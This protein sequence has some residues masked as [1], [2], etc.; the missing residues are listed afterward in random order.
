MIII[1]NPTRV[2]FCRSGL[3]SSCII[4]EFWV[5]LAESKINC[6]KQP[7]RGVLR[8]SCSENMQHIYKRTPMPKSDFNKVAVHFNW[9]HASASY[10]QNTFFL[11]RPQE[12]CFWIVY[13]FPKV[14]LKIIQVFFL[15]ATIKVVNNQFR[16]IHFY[17][18]NL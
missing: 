6:Q 12:G 1:F 5:G 9:N 18:G 3:R 11:G 13:V 2:V 10:F 17:Y 16:F 14:P 7:S 4:T 15:R 8:K